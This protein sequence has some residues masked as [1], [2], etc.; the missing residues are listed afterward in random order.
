[1]K[2]PRREFEEILD[3]LIATPHKPITAT[4]KRK[5]RKLKTKAKPAR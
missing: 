4:P 2:V 1:M 3:R 5:A